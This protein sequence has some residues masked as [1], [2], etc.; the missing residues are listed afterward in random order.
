MDHSTSS[1][2]EQA[3]HETEQEGENSAN[4]SQ[5]FDENWDL[6]SPLL[7]R[8]FPRGEP[9][10]ATLLQLHAEEPVPV[11]KQCE[12]GIDPWNLCM[13]VAAQ[14]MSMLFFGLVA[15]SFFFPWSDTMVRITLDA[16]KSGSNLPFD[17][18]VVSGRKPMWLLYIR[19]NSFQVSHHFFSLDLLSIAPLH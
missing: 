7:P 3:G 2:V 18:K 14:G 17:F 16:S 15:G 12:A 1:L 4:N 5:V 13:T 9:G 11:T 8:S 6:Q 19:T 10:P